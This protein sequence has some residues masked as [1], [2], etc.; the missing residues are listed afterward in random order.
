MFQKM[1]LSKIN[2]PFIFLFTSILYGVCSCSSKI[3]SPSVFQALPASHT[4]LNFTNKLTATPVFNMFTYMYFY[5]GA[6]AGAGDF[7]NDGLVDLFF[8]SNQGQNKLFLNR[9]NLKFR[10]VTAS[11]KIPQ[12]G[13]WSTGVSINDINNDGLLDIY[14]CRVGNYE[15]LRGKN[16][17][18]ICQG[19]DKNGIPYYANK[20]KEYGL[21]FSGFSTQA[22]FLDYDMDGDLDMYLL[23]H[24]IHE[25][26]T[27]ATRNKFQDT[28]SDVSGDKIY[29]N[30]NNLFTDV[31]KQTGI[32]ST[33]IGYGLGISIADINLDGYPD[34][35]V[36]N[37]FHE[38]DYLYINRQNGTFK[39]ELNDHI[40]HTSQF[41]M[42]VDIADINND[43][44][45]EIISV[46][47]LPS[48]PYILKRSLGEDSYDIFNLKISYGYNHQYTRNNL[49]L[50][51]GNGMYSETGMY[52]GIY[53]TDWSWAPLWL[54]FDNDGLKD[55]FISN[56]IPKRLNDIDYI[57]FVSNKEIQTKIRGNK[58][59]EKD[60]ALL[61]KFP[62]IKLPN[63]FFKNIG[64][65]KFK[66]ISAYIQGDKPT[67]SNGAVYADF[68]ND[69]DL[70]IVVNNIEDPVL[71]YRNNRN[72]KNDKHF[73]EIKLKGPPDNINAVGAKVIL[74]A[75]HTIRTYEKYPVHGFMS[76]ME[77]P[78]H[79]GLEGATIDSAFLIWPDNSYQ[80][81]QFIKDSIHLSFIYN[82]H[83]PKFNYSIL[84]TH[85]TNT[86][87]PMS[88]I[89]VSANLLFMHEENRF[90]EFNREPLIPHEV[91]AEGPALAI[92]DINNDGL[93]DVFTGSSKWKKSFIFLQ[94]PNGRFQKT[95]QPQ[96]E[97]DSTYEDVDACWADVNN[98]SYP[99]LI[100]AAGGNEFYGKEKYLSP[101]I[102][103]NDGRAH[104][105]KLNNAFDS[106]Y[107]TASCVTPYDF[108]NDGY[109]DLFIGG[110]AVP[111]QY[112]KI[113][114][115]Y[116]LQNDKTG[117]FKDVTAMYCK[118]LP[119]AGFIT[120]ALWCDI[121]NDGN[122]DLILSQEWGS[123][124]A[125]INHKG[126]FTKKILSEKNGWWNF[127]LPCDVDNDGD[128]DLIA[129]NY[130]LNNRFEN[131]SDEQPV[132]M[133]Y[134]DF[135]GNGTKEQVL[136]YYLQGREL[137]FANIAQIQKQL[138]Q[139]KKKFLY[140]EDFAKASL[141]DLFT[142]EKL[143]NA[144]LFTANYFASALF[145]N[146][147]KTNFTVQALPWQAQLS[148]CKDAVVLHAND[149]NL[150]D[151]L[152][153]GNF[154]A[155]TIE[156]G[157]YDA[158][159]GT[160][161]INKGNGQFYCRPLNGVQIRG[162][163]RRIRN[164][165]I[166]KQQAYILARNNDSLMVIKTTKK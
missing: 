117:R 95:S 26:G 120:H 149:D 134:N 4:G 3:G 138:P 66:N 80:P 107:L 111:W 17:L 35:Y 105:T 85:D 118:D 68:D 135:D 37:D 96:L 108:N 34:I 76:A 44:A 125:F 151:I 158:D 161:L 64:D 145:I 144:S 121:N 109:I 124:T 69:G 6:G 137:P 143:N 100:I 56:G 20:A 10:D 62:E 99:D 21:D 47:M 54:D 81:V 83:L 15:I 23:N 71:L 133:Y 89:T 155:C 2:Y 162:Q 86:T 38:N 112:G 141:N 128:I 41:S 127:T 122:K 40:M 50:N 164:I 61:N 79:I 19:I 67:Y 43:A 106:L 46:D 18:L 154:Y 142:K 129:G 113:P 78:V 103:L 16:Q 82:S 57:N 102:Y 13:A 87:K 39:E 140:A 93:D 110:R 94:Q 77:I 104:F 48:D 131:V 160:L 73:A 27:F 55:L 59:E 31:T 36:G 98:D 65:A 52:S 29:Q 115:S 159:F 139:L 5:N 58:L 22:A 11:A 30:D 51:R 28:Y 132:R 53:A 147:G 163:V 88:D 12:D 9:G 123:I 8:S 33:V 72:D 156:M 49:Q 7:N 91:S 24:S 101:R 150:P 146:D 45:P 136:T 1:N 90:V 153:A 25:N 157:R 32:N 60:L 130:G 84:T 148:P 152:L 166:A 97:S 63:E 74:F 75:N 42:G 126:S 119:Y 14:I 116:L 92:A 70:D 165:E 114:Q